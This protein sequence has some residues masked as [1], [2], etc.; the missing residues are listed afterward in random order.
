MKHWLGNIVAV[1]WVDAAAGARS[2]SALVSQ[3]GERELRLQAD[4]ELPIG[5]LV[6]V[7]PDSEPA[8]EGVVRAIEPAGEQGFTL[9]IRIAL[10]DP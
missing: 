6:Y 8:V 2:I 3:V 4:G 9:D 7:A 10:P 5:T 1:E